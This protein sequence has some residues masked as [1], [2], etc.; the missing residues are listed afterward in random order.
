SEMQKNSPI[1][2]TLANPVEMITRLA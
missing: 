1:H 2:D